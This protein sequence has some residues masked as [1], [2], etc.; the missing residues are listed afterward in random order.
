MATALQSAA[1]RGGDVRILVDK[2]E[3]FSNRTVGMFEHLIECHKA[4]C[5]IYLAQGS[6]VQAQYAKN[7]RFGAADVQG[8]CHT[9]AFAM[10]KATADGIGPAILLLGSANWTIASRC[11]LELGVMCTLT[12]N[13]WSQF[14]TKYDA[15]AQAAVRL[16]DAA[17]AQASKAGITAR[18]AS[19]KRTPPRTRPIV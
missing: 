13:G 10:C 6:S 3:V 12:W 7:G 4:G 5:R 1:Q 11:N 19:P 18:S 14:R 17:I 9:K 16:D 8:I 15:M 2:R